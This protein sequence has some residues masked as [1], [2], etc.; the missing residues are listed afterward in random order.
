MV[1]PRVPKEKPAGARIVVKGN[2]MANL[3][4]KAIG[5]VGK[6]DLLMAR[7]PVQRAFCGPWALGVA[8]T[9]VV[10]VGVSHLRCSTE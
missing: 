10:P 8:I 2:P 4:V 9:M 6:P 1:K 7:R 5:K 3:M